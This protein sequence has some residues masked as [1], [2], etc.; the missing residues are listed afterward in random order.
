MPKPGQIGVDHHPYQVLES[1]AWLP[2]Q[3]RG[4]F[5][6][7][8]NQEIHLGRIPLITPRNIVACDR[9]D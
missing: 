1:N 3:F 7:F 4:G 5:S 9:F 8:P 2:R 6:G